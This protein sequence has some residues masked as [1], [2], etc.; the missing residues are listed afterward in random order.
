M[1]YT[2]DATGK[3]LG[4]IASEAATYLMGKNTA[5]FAR[6]VA[7]EVAVEIVN[8]SKTSISENKRKNKD[9]I[10]YS[11]YPGGLKSETLERAISKK[12]VSE[13]LRRAIYGML[14]QNKLK[15]KMMKHLTITE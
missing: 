12:G 5:T 9:Y 3:K 6:N 4:R 11:G 14:P 13:A 8:A 1:K 15:A 2:I 7:P 10:T